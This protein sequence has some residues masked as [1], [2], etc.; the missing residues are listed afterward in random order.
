MDVLQTNPMIKQISNRER[1]LKRTTRSTLQE[2]DIGNCSVLG[3]CSSRASSMVDPSTESLSSSLGS[4]EYGTRFQ[5][6]M[7]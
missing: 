7:T 2:G 6:Q 4:D 1:R 5:F 3:C